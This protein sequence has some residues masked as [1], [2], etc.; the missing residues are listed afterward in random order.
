M[1]AIKDIQKTFGSDARFQL[2]GMSLDETAEEAQRYIKQN[3]LIW[4]HGFA[5]DL[6]AGASAGAVYKVRAI[7]AT[8]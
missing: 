4:T 8:F 3:G 7:P 5:G 6:L 1:P 2:I